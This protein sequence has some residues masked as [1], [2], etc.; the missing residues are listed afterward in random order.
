MISTALALGILIGLSMGLTGAGGGILAV[1]ALTMSLGLSL[2]QAA[3]IALSAVA[4]AAAV[5]AV[6][7]LRHGTVRYRAA[8]LMAALGALT[9]PLGSLLA[10][11]LP[12]WTLSLMFAA[13]MLLVAW[14]MFRQA[15]S[16]SL[17]TTDDTLPAKPCQLS[18]SSGR[19]IWNRSTA[20]TLSGIGA[21]SG[22]LTGLLGVGGGFFI[23]PAMSHFSNAGMHSIIAT[24]LMVIALIS[25]ASVMAS[26]SVGSLI[27]PAAAWWFTAA[28][29]VGLIV[30]RQLT[31]FIP[32]RVL[33]RGFAAV[34]ALVAAAMIWQTFY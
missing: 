18:L 23:V 20:L 3:P 24:S 13:V 14:R 16:P 8:L 5:G 15:R 7:G 33:Q 17:S 11:R 22:L 28:V 27:F 12:A 10:H 4:L 9:A 30:G 1:P 19:F 29:V 31:P 34:C 6:H 26:A 32:A 25:T 21:A 2:P